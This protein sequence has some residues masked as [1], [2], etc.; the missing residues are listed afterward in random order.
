MTRRD[1]PLVAARRRIVLLVGAAIGAL[2]VPLADATICRYTDADGATHYTNVAPERGW[3]KISC[4]VADE[5]PP[6]RT[7]GNAGGGAKSA[8]TP[9]GFP[10]VEPETQKSRDELRRRVLD[11]ELASEQ[12]LLVEARAAYGSGAPSPLPDEQN[13]AEKYRQR[14]ARLRQAVQLHERNV[15]ALRKE[16]A[17]NR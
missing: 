4:E 10:R 5:T 8:A 16:L 12:R 9:T 6:R 14:I 2:L 15:E 11:D 17:S 1:P 3:R 13:D 7:T